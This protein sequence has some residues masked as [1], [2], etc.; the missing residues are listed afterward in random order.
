MFV[1]NDSEFKPNF[2]YKLQIASKENP[3]DLK[4]VI[5]FAVNVYK[6]KNYNTEIRKYAFKNIDWLV[7]MKKLSNYFKQIYFNQ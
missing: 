3:I 7:K 5:D 1:G 6:N 4:H 2:P